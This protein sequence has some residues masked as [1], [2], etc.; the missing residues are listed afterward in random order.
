MAP[1][2][3][4]PQPLPDKHLDLNLDNYLK[5]VA[6]QRSGQIEAHEHKMEQNLDL[7]KKKKKKKNHGVPIMA[8]WL[9]NPTRNHEFVGSIPGLS[10]CVKDPAL[11]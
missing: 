6:K 1:H 2:L 9:T 8:Q 11:W 10:Q 5:A 7:P 3:G 4:L